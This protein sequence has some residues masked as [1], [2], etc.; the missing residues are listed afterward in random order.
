M[1]SLTERLSEIMTTMSW[2]RAD[3]MRVSQQSTSVISQWLGHSTKPVRSI[4][5]L[6][7]AIYLERA[8]G[9]SALWI[10]KGVGPKKV[11]AT[12]TRQP[13]R[14]LF[15]G[16]SERTYLTTDQLVSALGAAIAAVPQSNRKA[17][18]EN[19]A[20]W[21]MEGDAGPWKKIITMLLMPPEKGGVARTGT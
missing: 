4:G 2:Q 11:E 10:A 8:S 17:L 21:A 9:F 18:A 15:A 5:R 13:V 6:E 14:P 3:L 19:L 16:E 20:G 12:W 1:Q 7:A